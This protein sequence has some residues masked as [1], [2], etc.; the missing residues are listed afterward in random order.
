M[1]SLVGV[2]LSNVPH[3]LTLLLSASGTVRYTQYPVPTSTA[4]LSAASS[5]AN[6]LMSAASLNV[7]APLCAASL[8][9]DTLSNVNAPLCA[10][11]LNANVTG[12]TAGTR[13]L[14]LN[15]EPVTLGV[16]DSPMPLPSLASRTVTPSVSSN[17]IRSYIGQLN[18]SIFQS[19][20][21]RCCFHSVSR[22]QPI[23]APELHPYFYRGTLADLLTKFHHLSRRDYV[24]LIDAHDMAPMLPSATKLQCF[25]RLQSHRCLE[26][27]NDIIYTF[28]RLKKKR[29]TTAVQTAQAAHE[30]FVALPESMPHPSPCYTAPSESL[31]NDIIKECDVIILLLVV[32]TTGSGPLN[33]VM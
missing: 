30:A 15:A 29:G 17:P 14:R 24:A 2:L 23:V 12:G 31:R 8:N 20:N 19:L 28:T 11:S 6:T 21:D 26:A 25:T 7:N 18:P 33:L 13:N 4:P 5:N 10:A 16:V 9:A 3:L 32:V 22:G 27:C 1:E